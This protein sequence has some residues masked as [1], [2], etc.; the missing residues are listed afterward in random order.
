MGE[1]GRLEVTQSLDDLVRVAREFH[2][3]KIEI[4]AL[5]GGDGSIHWAIR[6]FR[7]VYGNDPL[8]PIAL[9]RGGTMNVLANNLG[10]RGRPSD[11]L[12]RLVERYGQGQ[13]LPTR[14]VLLI[15]ANEHFGF[16]FADRIAVTFLEEY[17]RRKGGSLGVLLLLLQTYWSCFR[18]SSLFPRLVQDHTYRLTVGSTQRQATGLG[19]FASSLRRMPMGSPLFHRTSFDG[20]TFQCVHFRVPSSKVPTALPLLALTGW[21]AKTGLLDR[22]DCSNLHA[23]SSALTHFTL[24]GEIFPAQGSVT[25]RSGGTVDFIAP[26]F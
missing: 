14:K 20:P 6:A 11:I 2:S 3:R 8:P 19:L 9:L 24:D 17:Y 26:T 1:K 4:L 25:L 10:I 15:Q 12:Y 13:T 5:N 18:G 21:K 22:F 7:Q 23:E 16:L